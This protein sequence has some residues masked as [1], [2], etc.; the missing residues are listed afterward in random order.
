MYDANM[1]SIESGIKP[2]LL[3]NQHS[4]D[5][6]DLIEEAIDLINSAYEKK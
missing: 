4:E 5:K 1:Q 2:H 3:V 6:D